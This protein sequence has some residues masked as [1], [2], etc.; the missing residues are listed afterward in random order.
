MGISY[1]ESMKVAFIGHRNAPETI[2][3][4]LAEV[5]K[6]LIEKEYADTFLFG[7]RSAFNSMCYEIVSDFKKAYPHIRRV[8]VRGEYDYPDIYVDYLLKYYEETFFPDR[9][10]GAGV[11]SYVVRNQILVNMCDVLVAYCDFGYEPPA[12]KDYVG[13]APVCIVRKKK[14]G[15]IMAMSYAQ[16]KKK[17]IINLFEM[18]R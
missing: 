9:V 11:L 15:T 1:C 10:R 6:T 2:K 3:E 18:T 7:S 4:R 17:T 8:Y 5:V 14:S 13:I 12:Q 16:Q